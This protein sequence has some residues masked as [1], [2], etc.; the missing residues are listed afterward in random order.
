MFP[1]DERLT[2]YMIKVLLENGEIKFVSLL[3]KLKNV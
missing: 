1:I 3:Q 2:K